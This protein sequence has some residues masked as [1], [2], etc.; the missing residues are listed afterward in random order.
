MTALPTLPRE[1]TQRPEASATAYPLHLV[2]ALR[3]LGH[4]EGDFSVAERAS[5]ETLAIPL[6]PEMTEEQVDFVA[7]SLCD[8]MTS[9]SRA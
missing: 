9:S 3:E 1:W 4:G 7:S 2:P 5:Q 8:V 6:Y